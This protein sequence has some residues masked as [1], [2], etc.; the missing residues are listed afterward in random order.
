V[1]FDLTGLSFQGAI[2]DGAS[3]AQ[4]NVS[5]KVNPATTA[6]QTPLTA[7][8]HVLQFPGLQLPGAPPGRRSSFPFQVN[9]D[10]TVSYPADGDG[11]VLSGAGTTTLRAS[12][13]TPITVD[14]SATS[15]SWFGVGGVGYLHASSP[16]YLKLVPGTYT[17]IVDTYPANSSFP[18][19]ITT[20]G[21]IS[22]DSSSAAVLTGAGSATLGVKTKTIKVDATKSSYP[23]FGVV[24]AGGVYPV[25]S[26]RDYTLM[27]GTYAV[28][29]RT[30]PNQYDRAAFTLNPDGTVSYDAGK[31][32][33]W[34]AGVGTTTLRVVK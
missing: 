9:G 22:Y 30:G 6:F 12:A 3:V 29:M 1:T 4:A 32:P 7:G 8:S 17:F 26:A 15:H 33:G 5:G 28:Q 10:G 14:M 31:Y 16:Q 27:P 18:I 20:S 2:V 21:L 23:A 24:N 25:S 34:F 13:T 19:T 11:G